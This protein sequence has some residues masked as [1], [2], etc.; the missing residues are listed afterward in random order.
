MKAEKTKRPR[1][2]LSSG[3]LTRTG[4]IHSQPPR[5]FFG[6]ARLA[7]AGLLASGRT[8]RL[9]RLLRGRAA[10]LLA[11]LAADHRLGAG[12]V[13]GLVEE[14]GLHLD[15]AVGQLAGLAL[16]HPR[17]L[18]RHLPDVAALDVIEVVLVPL[19]AQ[20]RHLLCHLAF[21]R[22]RAAPGRD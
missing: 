17:L 16:F 10:G 19:D 22:R 14:A 21:L 20:L 12:D 3:P 1:R 8:A 11:L 9:D 13:A 6:P 18:A 4:G 2:S 7:P 5:L 15:P